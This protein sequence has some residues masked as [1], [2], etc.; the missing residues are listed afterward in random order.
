MIDFISLRG[1]ERQHR[2]DVEV[3]VST[4]NQYCVTNSVG[5]A[6]IVFNIRNKI[7]IIDS[8]QSSPINPKW[9]NNLVIH[10]YIAINFLTSSGRS[11]EQDSGV[12]ILVD[13]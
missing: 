10:I 11:F 13:N 7:S 3:N 2:P 6:L 8:R 4:Y 9:P 12:I 1:I 5:V